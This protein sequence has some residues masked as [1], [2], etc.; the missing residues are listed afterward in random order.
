MS[1]V[2]L[3]DGWDCFQV[4]LFVSLYIY[5]QL[6]PVRMSELM[7]TILQFMLILETCCVFTINTDSHTQYVFLF[8]FFFS[9]VGKPAPGRPQHSA[10]E[11]RTNKVCVLPLLCHTETV[12]IVMFCNVI[13]L[14]CMR[15]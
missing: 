8:Y 12:M 4:H 11:L 14:C 6:F 10:L 9:S 7:L 3:W 13:S 1:L 2:G 15:V 5:V